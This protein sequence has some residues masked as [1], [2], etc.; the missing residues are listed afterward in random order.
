[1][2]ALFKIIQAS[3][4]GDSSHGLIFPRGKWFHTVDWMDCVG[5][6]QCMLLLFVVFVCLF[7]LVLFLHDRLPIR[8]WLKHSFPS[9]SNHTF[10][11]LRR[12]FWGR[13]GITIPRTRH[14][15]TKPEETKKTKHKQQQLYWYRY[16]DQSVFQTLFCT[17]FSP[18]I[19]LNHLLSF[20]QIA[21]LA[22]VVKLKAASC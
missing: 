9:E 6:C 22:T 8:V 20:L 2:A 17:S 3:K 19:R 1:M 5:R 10:W 12:Q 15:D 4:K 14:T 16:L 7:S 18:L 13:P 11:V 21:L